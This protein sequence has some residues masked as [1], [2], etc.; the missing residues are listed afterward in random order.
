MKYFKK[1]S[2]WVTVVVFFFLPHFLY[3]A[4]FPSSQTAGSE[5]TKF[6][7]EKAY[8]EPAPVLKEQDVIEKK[9]PE[10]KPPSVGPHFFLK[11]IH[12]TGNEFVAASQL[13]KMAAGLLRHE[14]TLQ[15]LKDL[16]EQIKN[17][18][19]AQGFIAVYVYLPPQQI[20]AG[21]VE[22]RIAEGKLDKLEI[23]GNRWFSEKLIR[24]LLRIKEGGIL[25]Y[26]ALRRGL[27]RINKH[28]DIQAK[29]VLGAG[30]SPGSTNADI[31]VKD[32]LPLHL[33]LDMNNLGTR[34]TGMLRYGVTALD[35]NLFGRL[36]Q[37][38]A[39][40]QIGKGT[41]AVLAD[42]IIPVSY[43]FGTNFGLSY[44]RTH[45]DVGGEFKSLAI[46]G[47]A[48]TYSGYFLQPL[49]EK[50]NFDASLKLGF[51]WK[52]ATNRVLGSVSGKDE[53]R[54]LNMVFNFEERDA[55]G[56]TYAPQEFDFGL[57]GFLGASDKI[58][59]RATRTGTGGQF[60]IYRGSLS[61]YQH[62]TEDVLL[63]LRSTVQLTPDRLA[64]SEQFRL[65]GAHSVRGYQEGEYLS[66]SGFQTSA[67]L[68]IPTYFFPKKWTL[69]Y[70]KE[71]LRKQI[72]ITS[73]A[74]IGYGSVR[75]P[76]VGE[77]GSRFL[78]G[79]GGGLRVHLFDKVYS[80]V[81]WA[82]PIGSKPIDHRRSAFYF[83]VAVE[84]P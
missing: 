56:Q 2:K 40:F 79:V 49:L 7:Q 5:E 62:I 47:D 83:G 60:F 52:S 63:S 27:I 37:L 55:Y 23:T 51:D 9:Q 32:K 31:Q 35:T 48:T 59:E 77:S 58:D 80:R 73:F 10:T 11:E 66:D 57:P 20:E 69:P 16:T 8:L 14:V 41:W 28:R 36:D 34:N 18:Y 39:R 4:P 25:K 45:V 82:A 42:Y 78:A 46:N 38:M 22:I 84:L 72:Q 33:G 3:A 64:P 13:E 53:L 6:K 70:S 30:E 15:D 61:R 29:A 74:D 43:R 1:N 17:Y 12:F 76:T 44:S 50:Q 68:L 54:I 67:E 26:D 75:S 81:E 24:N 71:P 21:I 19:R 65:G